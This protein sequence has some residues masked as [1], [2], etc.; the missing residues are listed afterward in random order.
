MGKIETEL[1]DFEK[2]G[3]R[4]PIFYLSDLKTK[5]PDEYLE[6][7]IGLFQLWWRCRELNPGH[8]GYEPYA[9]TI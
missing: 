8:Y 7:F 9:L 3:E 4:N 2:N 6:I 1:F 5:K